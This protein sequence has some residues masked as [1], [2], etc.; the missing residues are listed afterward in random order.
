MTTEEMIREIELK[1]GHTVYVGRNPGTDLK[2]IW[3]CVR[4]PQH[5]A[6]LQAPAETGELA[7]AKLYA[8]MGEAA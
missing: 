2:H 5:G 3:A 1:T 8:M 6:D 7:V 4:S